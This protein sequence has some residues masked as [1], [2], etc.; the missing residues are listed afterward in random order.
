MNPVGAANDAFVKSIVES[1]AGRSWRARIETA[2]FDQP[3]RRQIIEEIRSSVAAQALCTD[4]TALQQVQQSVIGSLMA[5]VIVAVR[6]AQPEMDPPRLL[7]G[8]E[9]EDRIIE[10]YPQPVAA[11]YRRL[12]DQTSAT[13]A[14]GCLLDTFEGLVHFL[15]AV[16]VSAY[17]RTGLLSAACNRHLVERFVKG[18]WSTGDLYA[19]LRD[20]IRTAGDCEGLLP[21]PE[22]PRYLFAERGQP[23][24]SARALESLVSL[25]NEVWGHGTGRDEE[26]YARILPANRALF[27]TELARLAWLES[28]ELILPVAIEES[29]RVTRADLLMGERRRAGRAYDLQ[30]QDH[31]LD[32]HGGDVRAGRS[33]LLVKADR[34]YLPLFPLSLFHFQLRTEGLYFLQ[35]LQWQSATERR[36]RRSWYVS[37]QAGLDKH[38][39]KPGDLAASSLELHVRR[40]ESALGPDALRTDGSAREV[41]EE[42]PDCQLPEVRHEQEFHRRM[43]AGRE[44]LLERLAEWMDR[45]AGGYLLL[46][47]LPGQ[48]KSALMAEFCYREGKRRGCLLHMVKSHRNP[49]KFVPALLSQAAKLAGERLGTEAYQGDLDDLRNSLVLALEKLRDARGRAL[50]VLDALDELEPGGERLG[51]LPEVLPVGVSVVLTCRPDIPLVQALR[52]RL[53]DLEEWQL[54]PLSPADLPLVLERRLEPG[55]VRQL[56]QRVDWQ[57]LFERVQGNPLFLQRALDQIAR[58]TT[59]AQPEGSPSPIDLDALPTTLA[60]L[61]Q[62]VYNEIAEKHQT[63]YTRPEG[64]QK[65]RLLQ[66]LCLAREPLGMEQLNEL[67]AADGQ[68]LSLE[69]CRDRV[70]EIS[71]YLL[72]TGDGQF[73]PW[74]QGLTDYVRQQVL[75]EAGCRQIE[76]VYCAW[77]RNLQRRPTGYGLRHGIKHLLACERFDELAELLTNWIL[78]E[79]KTNAGMVFELASELGEIA[80]R[81][82]VGHS[83]YHALRLLEQALRTDIYFIARHPSTL[84]QCLWNRAWWHDAPVAVRHYEAPQVGHVKAGPAQEIPGLPLHQLLETWRA[85]RPKSPWVRALRPPEMPLGNA[86]RAVFDGHVGWV[87]SVA[88]SRDSRLVVSAGDD[89]TVRLWDVETGLQRFCLQSHQDYVQSVAFSPD[90]RWIASASKDQTI[91]LWEVES[92]REWVRMTGHAGWIR[93]VAFSPDGRR[94]V[95]GGSDRTVRLWDVETGKELVRLEGHQSVVWCVAF[96]PD[97][98]RVASGS[99]GWSLR[100]WDAERGTVC[101]WDAESG[102]LLQRL[103]GHEKGVSS[104]AFSPDGRHI[105]TASYDGT[106]RLWDLDRGL[107]VQCLT[108]H[109]GEI[110]GIAFSADGLRLGSG[111][112]DK[113]VRLWDMSSGAEIVCLHTHDCGVR[114][115]ALSPAG[116]YLVSGA[117]DGTVR[118]WDTAQVAELPRLHNHAAEVRALAFS[119][120]GSRVASAGNDATIRLWDTAEGIELAC[121]RGHQDSVRCLAFSPN[122]ELLASGGKDRTVRVWNSRTAVEMCCLTGHTGWVRDLVFAPDGQRIASASKDGT[123][124][125]WDVVHVVQQHC[126]QGRQGGL[127]RVAFAPDAQGILSA[128][129][130]G[131]IWL[132]DLASGAGREVHDDAMESLLTKTLPTPWQAYCRGTEAVIVSQQSGQEIAWFPSYALDPLIQHPA[133][134]IWAGAASNHLY[135]FCLEDR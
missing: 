62:D 47:G 119:P 18:S 120:D 34:S 6:Q 43:F 116:D 77:L 25:R 111:G 70:L 9:L 33:L 42:D 20:T 60:G 1:E 106:I 44:P 125:V 22:L 85:Q 107:Q 41:G 132:W 97:N 123:V 30:L 39:E 86:Q 37:Y 73:K 105:A 126:L 19:L 64:R 71:Q 88:I 51:F 3:A 91:R 87:N 50:A 128:T 117:D 127:W 98:R 112:G 32:L 11:P 110:A 75:G 67:M 124:R 100:A 27:D 23:S 7:A 53:R 129:A 115:V 16:A 81:L 4:E 94:V 95:S 13:A 26:L 59:V 101:V 29:N 83:H 36:L 131:V 76:Q 38:E 69:D 114:S 65:S 52:S 90:G 40:L 103:E 56:G 55:I 78:L 99:A 93:S 68:P 84:F 12:T 92:G 2:Y 63:R 82:P 133:G 49:L 8:P 48:G 89:H 122:G 54:P 79:A 108:G 57:E 74:H 14:F 46:L 10:K 66:L 15:A 28:C 5:E 134:R 135:L 61:F 80:R 113:T 102:Q 45:S 121:L 72:D 104:I 17:L 118:L 58:W 96:S 130:D 24:A 109:R 35:R 21:Y 31:D